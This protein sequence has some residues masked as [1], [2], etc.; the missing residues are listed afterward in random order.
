MLL[1]IISQNFD[2]KSGVAAESIAVG[3]PLCLTADGKYKIANQNDCIVGVALESADAGSVFSMATRVLQDDI[4][5]AKSLN[6]R[7][8]VFDSLLQRIKNVLRN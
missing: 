5:L 7:Q 1:Q 3:L 4:K 6:W 2:K 8:R